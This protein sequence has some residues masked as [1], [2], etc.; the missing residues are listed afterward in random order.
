MKHLYLGLSFTTFFVR[1]DRNLR[2]PRI[3]GD[4][5]RETKARNPSRVRTAYL[6]ARKIT[7]FTLCYY[8]IGLFNGAQTNHKHKSKRTWFGCEQP[9][10]WGERCVTSQKTAAEETNEAAVP[11][12]TEK[13]SKLAR[14]CLQIRFWL[15]L[16]LDV[17]L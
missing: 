7:S 2:T 3:F 11:T 9:F 1:H 6:S 17:R 12:N 16:F 4:V 8:V 15:S 5:R 14:T 10:L 13:T